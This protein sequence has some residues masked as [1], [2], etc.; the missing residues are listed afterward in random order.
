MLKSIL[1][2]LELDSDKSPCIGV[3]EM[4]P[5]RGVCIGCL[6]TMEEI[7][8]WNDFSREEKSK[9]WQEIKKREKSNK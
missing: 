6:R 4:D 7:S 5:N 9:V 8:G 1:K 3:C 2:K